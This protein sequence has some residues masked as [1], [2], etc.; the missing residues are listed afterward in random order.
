[1]APFLPENL[2]ARLRQRHR[3]APRLVI[4]IALA[5]AVSLSLFDAAVAVASKWAIQPLPSQPIGE[6]LSSVSCPA[7][8]TCLAVGGPDNS[9]MGTGAI[10]YRWNGGR[11]SALRLPN[12]DNSSLDG[13]SCISR[14]SCIAVGGPVIGEGNGRGAL[15]M[16]WNGHRWS[17]L[18]TPRPTDNSLG[19]VSCVSATAC[20]ALSSRWG[21]ER[22]NGSSWHIQRIR[23][24][25]G[26]RGHSLGG[27]SCSSLTACTAVGAIF[28]GTNDADGGRTLVE[29][30]NGRHW[31]IQRT[32]VP[33]GA[34]L[35]Q[36]S[37][38]SC[39]A[40]NAC[41]AVGSTELAPGSELPLIDRWNGSNWSIQSS[42]GAGPV[43]SVSCPSRKVCMAVGLAPTE[44]FAERWNGRVWVPL[45]NP[46]APAGSPILTSLACISSTT[47]TAVGWFFQDVATPLV[48]QYS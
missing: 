31:A 30:W 10:A 45:Q 16:H 19:D 12:P 47:C 9:F 26:A 38:V 24:P 1:M 40:P 15:A 23:K 6:Q 35:S 32:P 14:R 44:A 20:T 39:S 36:L 13:V 46:P 3:A 33:A 48:D 27:V 25:P 4:G 21:A 29:H 7:K 42:R 5:V 22:W 11:W 2:R 37:D 41:T 18:S 43:S 17:V 28:F 34:L 8:R